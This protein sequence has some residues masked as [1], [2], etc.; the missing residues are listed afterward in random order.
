MV[1]KIKKLANRLGVNLNF[2]GMTIMNQLIS[3][4]RLAM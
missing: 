1:K 4:Y 3:F 2:F